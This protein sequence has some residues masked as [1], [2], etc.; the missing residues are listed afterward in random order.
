MSTDAYVE[1]KV[2]SADPVELIAFL[3]QAALDSVGAASRC[4][5]AGN[6]AA[7]SDAISKT[8]DILGLLSTSLD[9]RT[10]GDISRNL[11]GLYQYMQ[12]RLLEANLRQAKEPLAE[13]SGLLS[14]L[15]VAWRGISAVQGPHTQPDA[16]EEAPAERASS[17]ETWEGLLYQDRPPTQPQQAWSI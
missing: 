12:G 5:E 17:V 10:G 7:R 4:L 8:L 14:T 1:G 3:Y 2:L 13:V 11:E 6:I 16:P 15:A 9:H